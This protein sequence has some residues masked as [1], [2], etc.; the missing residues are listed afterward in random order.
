MK[1]RIWIF[2]LLIVAINLLSCKSNDD[3]NPLIP[4]GF[5]DKVG[6]IDKR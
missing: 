3:E 6:F 4:A 1:I 2:G 5:G